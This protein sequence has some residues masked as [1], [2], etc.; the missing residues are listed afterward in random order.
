MIHCEMLYQ[1]L[2]A[3]LEQQKMWDQ[4]ALAELR[5]SIDQLVLPDMLDLQDQ[6]DLLAQVDVLVRK[7]SIYINSH[8]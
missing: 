4:L 7:V 3:Q 6:P 2:L 5:T 1:D 8:F